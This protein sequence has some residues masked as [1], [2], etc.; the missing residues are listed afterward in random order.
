MYVCAFVCVCTFVHLCV[1]VRLCICVC[2]C[3]QYPLFIIPPPPTTSLHSNSQLDVN[4]KGRMMRDILN[5]ASF[6]LPTRE[7][8][9]GEP[10]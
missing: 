2:M 9:Y 7:Q 10:T 8:L 3:V 1:Y 5:M 4:I 6:R